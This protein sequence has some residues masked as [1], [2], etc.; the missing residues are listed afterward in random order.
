VNAQQTE[1]GQLREQ[2]AAARKDYEAGSF[3]SGRGR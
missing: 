2:L 1:I 3:V